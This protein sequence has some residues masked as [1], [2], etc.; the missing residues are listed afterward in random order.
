MESAPGEQVAPQ[1]LKFQQQPSKLC[2]YFSWQS[3]NYPDI[4]C[5]V[6][7]YIHLHMMILGKWLTKKRH[8]GK[9]SS[10]VQLTRNWSCIWKQNKCPDLVGQL[11]APMIEAKPSSWIADE[12]AFPPSTKTSSTHFQHL[13]MDS[14]PA[15]NA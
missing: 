2:T 9:L 7:S 13:M 5:L 6:S 11:C 3:L 8:L 10:T 14:P 1:F 15:P 4:T 12:I